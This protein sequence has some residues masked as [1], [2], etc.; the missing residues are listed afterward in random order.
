MKEGRGSQR[1]V[2]AC[3]RHVQWFVMRQ[4]PH[5]IKF[6]LCSGHS[7]RLTLNENVPFCAECV[8]AM[9]PANDYLSAKSPSQRRR[10]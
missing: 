8:Y 2:E 9:N 4:V 3:E 1:Y 5:P 6:C 10:P 7:N